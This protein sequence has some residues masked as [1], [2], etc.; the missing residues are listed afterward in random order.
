MSSSVVLR[1]ETGADRPPAA[2]CRARWLLPRRSA[3]AHAPDGA[4][5]Y[6]RLADDRLAAAKLGRMLALQGRVGLARL[7][8]DCPARR[9]A[10]RNLPRD[11][12]RP[13]GWCSP[14]RRARS[15]PG[16]EAARALATVPLTAHVTVPL[17]VHATATAPAAAQPR[18]A[19]ASHRPAVGIAAGIRLRLAL[20]LCRRLARHLG[21]FGKL[22]AVADRRNGERPIGASLSAAVGLFAAVTDARLLLVLPLPLPIEGVTCEAPCLCDGSWT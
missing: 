1:H 17:T 2:C 11:L 13:R 16:A 20:G 5:A 8:L 7:L 21:L 18:A 6:L 3:D 9:A 22:L 14:V 4:A 10:P 19:A 12:R 15:P